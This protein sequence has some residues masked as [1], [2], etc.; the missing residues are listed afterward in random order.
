MISIRIAVE[1][2]SVKD[3]I[4]VLLMDRLQ[5]II[6]FNYRAARGM[7]IINRDPRPRW[8]II[9]TEAVGRGSNYLPPRSRVE[10]Y[11]FHHECSEVF[12]NEK[13]SRAAGP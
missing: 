10:V 2:C 11:N 12:L 13:I 5:G 3:E 1:I 9:G 8:L 6:E 7:K 4:Y